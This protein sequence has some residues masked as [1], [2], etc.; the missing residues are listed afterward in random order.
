MSKLAAAGLSSTVAGPLLGPAASSACLASASARPT[1]SSRLAARSVV[2]SPAAWNRRS[3]SGPLSPMRTAAAARSA[4][5]GARSPR[6]TPLSRAPG[7]VE[8]PAGAPHDPA[9]DHA[10]AADHRPVPAIHDDRRGAEPGVAHDD[11]V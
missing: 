10:E 1:A 3:R 5:T 9:I 4:T 7:G 6:S 8:T 11:G 2:A